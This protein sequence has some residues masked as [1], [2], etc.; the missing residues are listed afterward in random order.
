MQ[1]ISDLLQQFAKS[2]YHTAL[3]NIYFQVINLG[4]TI[5]PSMNIDAIKG[6]WFYDD[7]TPRGVSFDGLLPQACKIPLGNMKDFELIHTPKKMA[8]FQNKE[9]YKR[10]WSLADTLM[11]FSPLWSEKSTLVKAYQEETNKTLSNPCDSE[12]CEHDASSDAWPTRGFCRGQRVLQK[13]LSL[14]G[15][16]MLGNND[17]DEG[18]FYDVKKEIYR[19]PDRVIAALAKCCDVKSAGIF[20]VLDEL[21][22]KEV[23]S[24]EG[25][26]NLASASA[27]AIRLRLSTYLE[28]GK[29]GELLSSNSSNK[30]GENTVVYYMPTDEELFHFFF[31]AIPLYDELRQFKKSGNIPSSFATCSFFNDSDITMGHI[32]CRLLKYEKAIECYELAVQQNPDNLCAEIRQIRLALLAHHTQEPSDKIREDLDNL[33]GK[34]VKNFFQLDT[35]DNKTLLEFTPLIKR[36]DMEE[37][38][39]LIEG[40]FFAHE[41]Y[42]SPKYLTVAMEILRWYKIPF[43][44]DKIL[45]KDVNAFNLCTWVTGNLMS[46]NAFINFREHEIDKIVFSTILLIE[47]EGVSTKCIVLLNSLGK[48]LYDQRKLDKAYSC[49]QR[50]LRMQ[51]LLYG[52][53]PN[54]KMMTSLRF[55]GWI[56]RELEMYEESK[57]YFESLAQRFESFGGIKSKL[58]IKETYLQLSEIK[59]TAD[60]TLRCIEN[61]LKITTG[62]K[63]E[64]ELLLNCLLY[65]HLAVKLHIQRSP[66]RAWEAVLNAQACQKACTDLQTKVK[67]ISAVEVCLCAIRKSKEGINMLKEELHELTSKSQVLEK[68]LCLKALGKLCLEQGLAAEAKNFY[69]QAIDIEEKNDEYVFHDLECRIGILEAA[70]MEDSV[71]MEKPILDKALSSAMKLRASNHKC[72]LLRKIG[73]LYQSIGEIGD[74]RLCYVET[75][76]SAKEL[77]DCDK[78]CAFL[79]EIGGL[80][81]SISDMDLA[82]QC[83][84]EALNTYKEESKISNKPPFLVFELAM[85]GLWAKETAQRYHFD[86]AVTILRQHVGTGHVISETIGL[87]LVISKAYGTI[88]RNM[89]IRLL[90]EGLK[91]SEIVYGE[92]KSQEMVTKLLQGLSRTYF[93]SGDMQNSRKYK[94]RQIKMELEL[95]SENP[96]IECLLNT[97]MEWAFISFDAPNSNDS[98]ERVCDFFLSSLNDKAFSLNTVATKAIAAKCFTFIAV[99]FYTSSNFEKARSLNEKA[100]QLFG[101]VQES[102]ETES[103]PFRKTCDLIKTIFSAE[104]TLPSHKTE[105]YIYLFN[106]D[107]PYPDS[108]LFKDE[109]FV[110]TSSF[111]N[112]RKHSGVG[113][114]RSTLVN[115]QNMLSP[116]PIVYPDLDALEHHKSQGEF[117][118]AAEIHASLQPQ[119][120]SFYENSPRDGEE[121]LISEA[122][123]AKNKNQPSKAIRLLDLALQLQLPEGQCRQTTK[124]LKL[125]AECLLSMGHFRSAAIDFTIADAVYSIKT[126]NNYEDLCEYSEVLIGLI[127]SEILCNNVEAAWLVS[128]RGI[129]LVTDHKFKENVNKQAEKLLY[130]K[131]RC[132]NILLE[133]GME[134]ENKLVPDFYHNQ[135]LSVRKLLKEIDDLDFNTVLEIACLFKDTFSPLG[136]KNEDEFTLEEMKIKRLI[137]YSDL[138][139]KSQVSADKMSN[140]EPNALIDAGIICSLNARLIIQSGDIEQSINWLHASLAAFCSAPFPDFMWYYEEF[141]PLLKAITATKS[142]APDQSRSPF[143]QAVDMCKRTLT[144]RSSSYINHFLTNLIIIYRSLGQVHEAMAVAEIGLEMTD[145]TCDNSDSDKLKNRGRMLLHLAQ[146]HQQNS[147]NPA[148]NADDELNRAEHYYLHDREQTE[149]MV[150]CKNLSYANFL[151]E[152]K[153]FAEAVTVLEDMRNLGELLRN[154]YLYAEYFS[155]AFYG[156]GVEKSVKMDG[157]LLTTVENVLYNLLVRAYVGIRKRKEAVAACETLTDVNAPDVHEPV[158]GKRPS[159]K[160]YLVEDCHRELLSLLNDED[161]HQFQNGDF[162]LSTSN[163]MKL[164]YMLGEY[165][166]AVKYL[167]KDVKSPEMLEMK[168]SCLRLAGNELIDLNRGDESISFFSQFLEMLQDK[169]GFL[170]KRFNNQCEILQTCYFANQYYFFRSLGEIHVERENIDAAIQCYERCI[171]LDKDFTYNQDIVATLSG[172]YQIKALTVDVNDED[173]RKVYMDLAWELFQK[174]FQQTSELT[175]LVEWSF[176]SLLTRLDRNEEAVEHFYK[177]IERAKYFSVFVFVNVDKPLMD[178]YLRR[179]IEALGGGVIIQRK[180]LAAYELV[181]TLVKLNQ[182]EKA[183]NVALF[184]ERLVKK[185]RLEIRNG[186]ITHSVAG[187][188][189]KIIGNK[190]K[191]KE[192]F[193]NVLK[194]N[195]G[196]PPLTEALESLLDGNLGSE[197]Q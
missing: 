41:I 171:E 140:A 122:M 90:L 169:E 150:L 30:T 112:K 160:P 185:Y 83:Y 47:E 113:K 54:A 132:I 92:D 72:S 63:N 79:T 197:P 48:F 82:R 120:L 129:K 159:C 78:K 175:T 176:A 153:R 43:T 10:N 187:Y 183:Q 39:Q 118:L 115:E 109:W 163:L 11:T 138:I 8:E 38:Q 100:S 162:P 65:C 161:R 2:F 164:Y 191:A 194:V 184:L 101:E 157:E 189:Y 123:E 66:E 15:N 20:A 179:E 24:F 42:C 146:I 127:K 7:V 26:N 34:L 149:Y 178:V 61:G 156:A 143:Q 17:L 155:C 58:L 98:I 50:S 182:K 84:N 177:V 89:E 133:R 55:L 76:R 172:L 73:I 130:L 1:T 49:F 121:K 59:S 86:Q 158:Y 13:D 144:N 124:I 181:L 104:I 193:I 32:Y 69:S 75:A 131:V 141:L 142:S 45:R 74:A 23:I 53:R 168:I 64:A 167:P 6:E 170:D 28:T 147:S 44:S 22:E 70:V 36:V 88:D 166:M 5:L 94:E 116:R 56:A 27:I 21:H 68:V 117:R 186:V 52:D 14:Y 165:E 111:P 154:E 57:F 9:W 145:F 128:E 180:V 87:F 51:H 31:V 139:S 25:R 119:Q 40:L 188:A 107:G 152:R 3:T 174:L 110:R 114:L 12:S 85:V 18:K 81:E 62:G 33:L 77:H 136:Q 91:V 173:S 97:L 103:D 134:K 19:L 108:G 99:L 125:R 137:K 151:C 37:R 93:L 95:Y 196:H 60:E 195:P 71:S 80:C 16:M 29:Q 135:C 96:F 106:I 4:E 126:I 105:L 35:N 192:I 190:E 67:M 148:F 46:N 102:F